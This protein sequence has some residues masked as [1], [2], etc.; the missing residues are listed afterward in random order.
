MKSRKVVVAIIAA[1]FA[2][3]SGQTTAQASQKPKQTNSSTTTTTSTLPPVP[4]AAE[5]VLRQLISAA[6]SVS[7]DDERAAALSENYDQAEI[8]LQA[9]EH[10]V[11]V[12]KDDLSRANTALA[13]Q[14]VLLR[15][16]AIEAYVTGQATAVDDSLLSD[17]ASAA[18]MVMVYGS[19]ATVHIS[20]AV[21]AYSRA[22]RTVLSLYSQARANSEKISRYAAAI[23]AFRDEAGRLE[24]QAAAD[25]DAIKA[26][27]LSLV[28]PKEY[29]RLLSTD[30]SGRPYTGPDL[31]GT[32]P[33]TVAT[34][35]QGTAAVAAAQKLLGVPYLWGGATKQGV[36]CSGLTMLAWGAAG[37]TLEHSATVQWEESKPVPLSELRPGDLLFYHFADDGDT[38]ITHVVMYVGAGPYGRATIIQAAH[39]G[40]KVS[41]AAMYFSGLV[42]AGRP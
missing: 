18:G 39:T 31:A 37:I 42:S 25:L 32:D 38:A 16:A 27:L 17:S 2:T 15:H 35:T 30:P 3:V 1:L 26:H 34:A 11:T 9:A 41:Y 21:K 14:R 20:S 6:G 23:R 28:G 29:G 36:D 5:P 4:K 19:V 12:L 8:K 22:S 7:A 24:H 10:K 33:G 40:T 13:R